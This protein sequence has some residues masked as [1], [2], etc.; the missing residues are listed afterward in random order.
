MSPTLELIVRRSSRS[1]IKVDGHPYTRYIDVPMGKVES[2][3]SWWLKRTIFLV[4]ADDLSFE[5]RQS[6]QSGR[7]RKS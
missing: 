3:R 5:S 2:R 4:K 1:W 6:Y 7:S